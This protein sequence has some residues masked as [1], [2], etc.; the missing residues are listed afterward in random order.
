[1]F[2]AK[3]EF[4][5]KTDLGGM[6]KQG[7]L[8]AVVDESAAV[9]TPGSHRSDTSSPGAVSPATKPTDHTSINTRSVPFHFVSM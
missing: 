6:T 9:V 8:R 4:S 1:V 2:C 3:Q 5:E 7:L